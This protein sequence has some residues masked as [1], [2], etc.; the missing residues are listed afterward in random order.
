VWTGD[1]VEN[2]DVAGAGSF[3]TNQYNVK[4]DYGRVASPNFR[5]FTGGS[6]DLPWGIMLN[7][8]I[9]LSSEQPYNI[10]SG[11]DLNGDTQYNDRPSFATVN[12]ASQTVYHTSCGD[13]HAVPDA[14]EKIVPVN[15][16]NG[17]R[18][19]YTEMYLSKSFR[20]GPALPVPP[21]PKPEPGK[22]APKPEPPVLKYRLTFAVEVDNIFNHPNRSVPVGV[23]TSPD[24]G[25][26][27]SLNSTFIGS[28]NANR[29]IFL[30]T[31]FH[32]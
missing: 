11:S 8:F 32:F 15:C 2:S 17:P 13:L 19:T 9:G 29:M 7:P 26:T 3:P 27:L 30:A 1:R 10:T 25:K 12:D 18:F 21:A 5:M 20:F 14:G 6:F 31:S 23:L 24:F 22:P 28:P 4:A 16:A